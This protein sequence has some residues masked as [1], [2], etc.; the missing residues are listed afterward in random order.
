VVDLV[1]KDQLKPGALPS[2]PATWAEILP[3]FEKMH[4]DISARIATLND[5]DLNRTMTMPVGPGQVGNM[6]V[7][8]ALWFFLHDTIH[9]RGQF[10]VYSR[11]AGAKVPSIY[12]PS[13]DE[14][15]F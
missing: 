9:H 6:R 12:G 8:E 15:W 1:L 2:A 10:S 5:E 3:A 13:A 4:R 11:I 7:A 14:P